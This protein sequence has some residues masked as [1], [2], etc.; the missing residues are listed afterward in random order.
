MVAH[1]LISGGFYSSEKYSHKIMISAG[2][3]FHSLSSEEVIPG[4]K[5]AMFKLIE[6]HGD[7]L[8]LLVKFNRTDALS[9]ENISVYFRLISKHFGREFNNI[10]A[11][12]DHPQSIRADVFVDDD[13]ETI[14]Y[15]YEPWSR[16]SINRIK[17]SKINFWSSNCHYLMLIN[18]ESPRYSAS[19][20]LGKRVLFDMDY[21]LFD[22]LGGVLTQTSSMGIELPGEY[23]DYIIANN[24]PE[25]HRNTVKEIITAKGFYKNLKL[26]KGAKQGLEFLKAK[27]I[28]LHI[29]SSQLR[30]N[31]YCAEEKVLSL[32]NENICQLFEGV[33]II[34]QKRLIDGDILVDDLDTHKHHDAIWELALFRQAHNRSSKHHF[35]VSGWS[36]IESVL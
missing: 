5:E 9:V 32:A 16:I 21:V 29:C 10:L 11:A 1:E 33:H 12:S 2:L 28:G 30:S 31:P 25:E 34:R 6:K 26:Y 4:A 14:S 27:N 22:M 15:S 13:S 7:N 23:N 17:A 3:L 18:S 24:F 8:V 20:T 35:V 19:E 36:E